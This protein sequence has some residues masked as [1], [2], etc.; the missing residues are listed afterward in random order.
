M[1][2]IKYF[3]NFSN[4]I[5][6]PPAVVRNI[7]NESIVKINTMDKCRTFTN[8]L[9]HFFF[10]K[11]LKYMNTCEN[12][13]NLVKVCESHSASGNLH[14]LVGPFETDLI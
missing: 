14:S 1:T 13:R 6:F 12:L 5:G 2:Q 4:L 7:G 9:M 3:L 10:R 8:I 11:F